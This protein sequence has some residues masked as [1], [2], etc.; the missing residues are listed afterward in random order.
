MAAFSTADKVPE[1]PVK[2]RKGRGKN[3]MVQTAPSLHLQELG[4]PGQEEQPRTSTTL[5]F[6]QRNHPRD[7]ANSQS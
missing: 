5:D 3:L 7:R 4:E 2:R 6:F 1:E